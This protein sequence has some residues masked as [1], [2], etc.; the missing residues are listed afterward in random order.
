MNHVKLLSLLSLMFLIVGCAQPIIEPTAQLYSLSGKHQMSPA[1]TAVIPEGQA[2]VL[3]SIKHDYPSEPSEA[4]ST[5]FTT[6]SLE[7]LKTG[8][9]RE[10][11]EKQGEINT[12]VYRSKEARY[13]ASLVKPGK[14]RYISTALGNYKTISR[15]TPSRDLSFTV[16]EGEAIYVGD[17]TLNDKAQPYDF[18][19]QVLNNE[20]K[21]RKFY[22]ELEISQSIPLQTRLMTNNPVKGYKRYS[23][24][25]CDRFWNAVLEPRGLCTPLFDW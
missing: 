6:N 22:S 8:G 10:D 4:V 15:Y 21:A 1:K 20:D 9:Y 3:L 25:N 13:L 16:S 11:K 2:L 17:L 14:Y 5:Y 18:I 24:P 7:V 12:F 23:N 19:F